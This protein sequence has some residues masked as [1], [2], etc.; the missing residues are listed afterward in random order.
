LIIESSETGGAETVFLNLISH[1]D[2]RRYAPFVG[3]LSRGWLY[4][5]VVKRGLVPFL[6]PTHRSFDVGLLVRLIRLI[7]ELSVDLVHSHLFDIRVYA[8]L[9][10]KLCG[11]PVISTIHGVVDVRERERLTRVKFALLNRCVHKIVYVSRPLLDH[12]LQL[13]YADERISDVVP[14]GVDLD[15]FDAENVGS[16]R[17][18]LGIPHGELV[19]GAVG[20]LRPAKGYDVLIRAASIV[21]TSIPNVTFIV[22][23][24]ETP[25]RGDLERLAEACGVSRNVRFLGFRS[26]IPAVLKTIDIYV[27]SSLSEGF[28]L[29]TVEAMAAGLPVI[30]TKCGGPEWVITE[31]K[32]GLLVAPGD[33][34]GLAKAICEVATDKT[35]AARLAAAATQTARKYSIPEMVERYQG[36]YRSALEEP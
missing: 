21:R 19:I 3:L 7:K 12:F 23:G 34:H 30:C 24:S 28:S 36:L 5:E 13:E 25:M 6:V 20:D 16:L 31:G 8:A 2:R 14:N 1:L 27:L 22:A 10:G 11:I 9:A 35:L 15:R 26:D 4:D 18:E 32:D 33:P 17:A 29:T